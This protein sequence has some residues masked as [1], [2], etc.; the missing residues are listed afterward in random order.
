M[1]AAI[2]AADELGTVVGLP[3]QIAQRDAATIEV[4]LNAGGED[5]TGGGGTALGKGPE[6]QAAAHFAGGVFDRRE[7]ED[8]GLG[9]VAGDIVE[10]LGI[11]GDLLKDA[12][13]G[14]DVGEVLFALI[15]ALAFFQ[16]PVL[17]PDALQS[18]MAEGKIELANETASAEGEQLLAQSD[19]LLFDGGGSLAGL[20]MRSAGTLD[21][22]AQSLLLIAAQPLAHGGD[23]G[24]KQAGGRLDA[25]LPSRL[26]QTQAMIVG[27][28]HFTHQEEVRGR[29]ADGIVRPDGQPPWV[30]EKWKSRP[31][32][33]RGIPTF[34]PPRRRLRVL[35]PIP[36]A[37]P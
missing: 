6:Q 32:K 8:L 33:V 18:T 21:E 26:H 19:D 37:H 13:S 24:L 30:V 11:G 36:Q 27:V 35:S 28:A 10:V 20:V 2:M 5:G 9:P 3:D 29:H 4:L 17:A 12:P 25:S 16:Q 1:T 31:K 34:P 7:I 15:F 14:L 22:A 23:G